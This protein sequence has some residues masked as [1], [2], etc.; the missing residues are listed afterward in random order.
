M[1]ELNGRTLALGLVGA[2]A[3]AGAVRRRTSERG[4][5]SRALTDADRN[6][7]DQ[8]AEDF[9]TYFDD[10]DAEME[11]FPI[12]RHLRHIGSGEERAV[13]QDRLHPGRVLKLNWDDPLQTLREIRVWE[14]APAWIRPHLVPLLGYDRAGKWVVMEYAKPMPRDE[15]GRQWL[16][17]ETGT[18]RR[19]ADCGLGDAFT[20]N[21][22]SDG[23]L[24]DYGWFNEELWKRC[25]VKG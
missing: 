13:F 25:R 17:M 7:Y 8:I 14:E 20:Q 22:S 24:L 16:G 5:P 3:L 18:A 2:L 1:S 9:S 10:P 23:R 11:A 19:L 4:S 12:G 15:A 21:L 6:R